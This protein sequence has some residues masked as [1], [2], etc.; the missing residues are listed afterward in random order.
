MA[1]DIKKSDDSIDYGDI[2]IPGGSSSNEDPDKDEDIGSW[3][4]RM[5]IYAIPVVNVIMLLLWA[6]SKGETH[7]PRRAF[8]IAG[9]VA[10]AV[11]VLIGVIILAIVIA[12]EM[13]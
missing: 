13:V 4:S 7:K 12:V 8:A 10:L 3:I 6:T 1:D 11:L 5:L 9:L 2:K